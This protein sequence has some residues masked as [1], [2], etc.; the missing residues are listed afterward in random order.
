[1]S[2]QT[3]QPIF[4]M[5]ACWLLASSSTLR[6]GEDAREIIRRTVLADERNWLAARNYGFSER[7]DARRLDDEGR[8]KS[9]DVTSYDVL[10]LAGSPYRRLATR[11]DHPLPPND[12]RKEQEKLA[13]SIAERRK[14]SPAQRATRLAE[15][16]GRPGWQREAWHELPDAFDFRLTGHETLDGTSLHVIEATPRREYRPRSRTARVMAQL[17]GKLWIDPTDFR[18]VKAEV[19]VVETISVGLILVRLAKG[20]RAAFEQTMVS[21]DV[22]LPCRVQVHASARVGLIRMLH[23]EQEVIYSKSREFQA[24]SLLVTRLGLR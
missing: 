5:A 21:R 15:Y 19:R 13:Q 3:F 2:T 11:N 18:L 20:S 23:I 16:V 7:V 10:L 24:D 17:A 22:W 14:E 9:K 12:E 4:F 6:A 1:M 8:L